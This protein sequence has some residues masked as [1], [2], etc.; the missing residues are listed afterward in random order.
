VYADESYLRRVFNNLINNAFQ[1]M[2]D[3]GR[4]SVLGEAEGNIAHF[5]VSDTGMGIKEEDRDSIF[6][7]LFTT[8]AKGT[9]LGLA[10]CK[11][12]VNEHGGKIWFETEIGVGTKFHV[13]L[14]MNAVEEN[15]D[16]APVIEVSEE[17]VEL[18]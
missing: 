12:V 11:R 3:G 14:P 10:V 8:K 2:P 4:L 16:P 6:T 1:A 13:E 17:I 15:E 9:G 5:T 7:A 18:N